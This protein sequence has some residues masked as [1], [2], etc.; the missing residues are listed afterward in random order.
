[1]DMIGSSFFRSGS[2]GMITACTGAAGASGA[3]IAI[4]A[5]DTLQPRTEARDGEAHGLGRHHVDQLQQGFV[6]LP[7]AAAG[8]A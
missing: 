2:G 8:L 6:E 3:I 1:M 4:D 7:L 5:A